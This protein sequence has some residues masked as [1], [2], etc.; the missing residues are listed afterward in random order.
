[1]RNRK[2][3]VRIVAGFI[4]GLLVFLML[5]GLVADLF[6]VSPAAAASQAQVNTLKNKLK[7]AAAEKDKIKKELSG[8]QNDKASIKKQIE[9]LDAQINNT[10]SQ[11]DLRSGLIDELTGMI[12]QKEEEVAAAQKK[13][14]EQYDKFKTRVRVMY[15]QGDTSYLEV[16]L[17]SDNFSDFLSRYEIVSQIARYDKDL[18]DQLKALKEEIEQKKA[19][20]EGD[21]KEQEAARQE[22][23]VTKSELDQQLA[24]RSKAM[25]ALESAE[26]SVK[27]SYSEIEKEEE[28]INSQIDKMVKEMEEEAKKQQG[29]NG[30]AYVGGTFTWPLP[31]YSTIS[32]PFGMRKHPITGVYKLHTGVDLSAPRG[33]TIVAANSGTVLIAGYSTAYGNYV[34]ISHGGGISTLYAHMSR[35]GTSKGATVSAGQKIG[36]V[37]STGYSTGNHLHFEIRKNGSYIDPMTQF[38]RK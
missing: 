26:A 14:Q 1:M 8:I 3:V 25:S 12:A 33:T 13:E 23:Q 10:Q 35:I 37:G 11:I 9:A 32:C 29:A 38:S 28:K 30:G 20:L 7:D 22:L 6:F 27:A 4:A 17:S 34:V 15:E 21:K 5:F 16:L 31:G 36:E 19:E 2:K 24:D 18:F